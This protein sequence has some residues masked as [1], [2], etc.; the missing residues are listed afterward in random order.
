MIKALFWLV[1]TIILFLIG[2]AGYRRYPRVWTLP[3]LTVTAAMILILSLTGVSHATYMT[4]G[5]Y[6]TKMLGPAITAFA[7]PLYTV[8]HHVRRFLPEIG[9]GVVIGTS[10]ALTS[11]IVF[12]LLLHLG[13]TTNLALLPK[14]VTLPV[15]LSISERSGGTATLTATFVL[16]TGLVGSLVGPRLMTGLKIHHFVSRG[17]G[18]ASI[19]HV[20]GATKSMTLDQREGAVGLL[21]MVLTAIF[22]SVLAP[23]IIQFIY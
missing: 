19:A 8:R 4:G 13:R 12:G 16:M 14:S 15:A 6:L 2:F 20:M 11:D 22:A 9:L 1:L 17:V 5:Q 21:T 3:I 10:I 18:L 23:F 7:I